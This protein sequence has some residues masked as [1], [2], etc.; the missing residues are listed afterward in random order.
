MRNKEA[1]NQWPSGLP[2]LRESER[3]FNHFDLL[4]KRSPVA[5]FT[6]SVKNTTRATHTPPKFYSTLTA[7]FFCFC[8]AHST[9]D[10]YLHFSEQPNERLK[11]MPHDTLLDDLNT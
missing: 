10:I 6:G 4:E 5:T 7:W 8:F 3:A 9:S 1:N 11:L 2:V